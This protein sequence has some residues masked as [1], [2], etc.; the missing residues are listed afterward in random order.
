MVEFLRGRELM[1]QKIPERLELLGEL[2]RNPTGKV[3]KHA[4]RDRYAGS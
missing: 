1:V 4:L 3:V 2:P